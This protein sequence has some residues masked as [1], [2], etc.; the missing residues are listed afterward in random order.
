MQFVNYGKEMEL[1]RLRIK[2]LILKDTT[3]SLLTAINRDKG[4]LLQLVE[5]ND[6]EAKGEE[7]EEI[8]QVFEK[9][10]RP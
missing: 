4:L 2:E 5:K 1:H 9:F 8:T 6:L 7:R 3:K 10:F